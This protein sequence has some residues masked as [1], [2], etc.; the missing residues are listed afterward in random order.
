MRRLPYNLA[1]SSSIFLK[2][3]D[4]EG[5]HMHHNVTLYLGKHGMLNTQNLLVKCIQFF[6]FFTN[7]KQNHG[8]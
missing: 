4:C 5:S 1:R 7:W 8:V 2:T 6:L 3:E